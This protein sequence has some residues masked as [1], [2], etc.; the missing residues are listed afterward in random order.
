MPDHNYLGP[1]FK[2]VPEPPQKPT[3]NQDGS[4]SHAEY[5]KDQARRGL[6]RGGVADLVALMPNKKPGSG[7]TRTV[8]KRPKA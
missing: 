2:V 8:Y 4:T 1:Q 5:W 6:Y 3:G 7:G